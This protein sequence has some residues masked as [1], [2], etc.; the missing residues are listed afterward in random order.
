M[1]SSWRSIRKSGNE[2]WRTL[3]VDPSKDYTI[4]GA[5]RVVKGMVLIG[6]GG[7]EFGVRGYLSAYDGK[8][9]ALRWRFYTVPGDPAAGFENKAME[10]AAKTWKGQW[11]KYGGGGTVWDSFVF[12]PALNLVYMG[13]GNGGPW[14][15]QI[16]SPGGGDNLYLSS[17]VA[18]NADT[19]E[20]VWHYQ[21][22]PGDNWDFTAT[23]Q[24]MLADIEWKGAARKVLMQAPKNGFFFILD[25]VTGE[26]LSAEPYT[27]VNWAKGYDA[28]GRPIVVSEARYR[29]KNFEVT[30][31][32]LGG[33]NWQPMS[34]SPDTG[35]VYIPA[36]RTSMPFKQPEDDWVFHPHHM[37]T[38]VDVPLAKMDSP[39]LMQILKDKVIRGEL[40][41][42]DPRQQRR[43]WAYQHERTWNGGTLATASKLVFQGTADRKLMAFDAE[44]GKPLWQYDTQLGIIAAP[45]TYAVNGEQYIAVPAK[46]GGVVP[47]ALGMEPRPGLAKGR[48]LAFKIGGKDVLP[49]ATDTSSARTPP[50]AMTLTDEASLRRGEH[51][52]TQACAP[53][54]GRDVVGGGTVPDLRRP[55]MPFDA[56]KRVVLDGDLKDS[57][58]VGFRDLLDEQDTEKV[59][60][61]V[62]QQAHADYDEQ[63][64]L[65]DGGFFVRMKLWWYDKL[66]SVL[67]WLTEKS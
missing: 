39:L 64:K 40:V 33:H 3:T 54:H 2:V 9:G 38:G 29:E 44:T 60:N 41:A 52:F 51:L 37:N 25:R 57:G 46:W 1:A 30:P 58:M 7:A 66:S 6:N 15:Q 36:L 10:A 67:A 56:F 42:W 27:K 8:T 59:Y 23:Q 13:V 21:E 12:D 45:V 18:V 26:L 4:T 20:Y 32:A 65:K 24:I 53:C 11:W 55:V 35:L 34:Y 47:L 16:R 62:L 5:P 61:Y 17:I 19:G 63:E 28:S 43:A 48:L 50:P 31:S 49:P 22:T 14:N